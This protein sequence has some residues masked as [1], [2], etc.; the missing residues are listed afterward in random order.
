MIQN[1]LKIAWRNLWSQKVFSFINIIGLTAG[2]TCCFLIVLFVRHE[3]S[4]DQFQTRFDRIH[5]I[6]YFPRFAGLEQP[7]ALTP[8]PVSPLLAES[9]PEVEA[10]AR[11]FRSPATVEVKKADGAAPAKYDEDR[12]FFTDPAILDIFSFEFIKGNPQEALR[13][14]FSVVLSE[15]TARRYFGEADPLG[16]TITYEGK[17]PLK[18]AG[19]VK[20]YP[21]HSHIHPELLANYETMYATENEGARQNIPYNWIISH[22]YTYVLL[23]P[24]SKAETINARF[25]QFI[26]T[27]ADAEV[28]NGIEYRLEPMKDFYLHTDAQNTPEPVSSMSRLYVFLGIAGLTLLIACINFINLSTARSL[29]RAKEVGLRKVMGSYRQQL[30]AQ[31]L[32]E[33]LLLSTLALGLALVLIG[34]L[35]P[36]LNSL[37]DKQLTLGYFLSDGVLVLLFVGIAVG[38]GVLSGIYPALVVSGF[39]PVATLKGNFLSGKARGG[40]LRQVLL[41][42]QFVASIALIIGT[43]VMGQQ[44]R[45]LQNRPLGFNKD[46]IITANTR[47]PKITNV[48]A[49]ASDSSYQRL[50]TFREVLLQN[51][52]IEAVT[53]SSQVLGDG[54]VRRNVVPEGRAAQEELLFASVLAVDYNFAGTYGLQVL[55]GRDFSEQYG[56]DKSAGYLV[57][58]AAVKQFGWRSAEAAVGKSLN[59]EGK[60]GRVVGVLKDFHNQSLY[61][62]IASLVLHIEPPQLTL[63]SIKL[64]P[65]QVEGTL[66]AVQSTWDRYFPEKSFEYQFL[67]RNLAQLYDREQR[68]GTLISYFAGLAILISCLGLYG[69][70]ALVTQQKTREIGIRK[71]LGASVGS[72]VILLAKNFVVLVLVAMVIAAP[73]AWWAMDQWLQEFAYKITIEWWIF[74]AAGLLTLLIALLTVSFQSVRAALMNPVKSLRSE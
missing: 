41:G 29:R 52:Q 2:L 55:A 10:S 9:F 48:F 35:L 18:V 42:V 22:S 53:L 38:A 37:T 25:P 65:T 8:P 61:T 63:V 57:N 15:K 21:D 26:K 62:P 17:Y 1:Y 13:D 72:V 16:Q 45:F 54:S 71:V 24:D 44:L 50:S 31:F 4:Y 28:A 6:T 73:L 58:E 12:F 7:L 32:G 46:F 56:T 30:I 47:S 39:E 74:A 3:L 51:P 43:L 27:H 19:V 5:R 66:Q 49:T 69:L 40:V 59:V 70:I 60:A 20:D 14:K 68:R 33:S 67:D 64:R 36:L 34:L 11:M 23:R